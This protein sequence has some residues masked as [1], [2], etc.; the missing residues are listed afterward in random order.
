MKKFIKEYKKLRAIYKPLAA[1]WKI[2]QKTYE[3][4][5]NGVLNRFAEN[6]NYSK[7]FKDAF[8]SDRKYK[9]LISDFEKLS[10]KFERYQKSFSD[11]VKGKVFFVKASLPETMTDKA[12]YLKTAISPYGYADFPY[13]EDFF[14]EMV[15]AFKAN[16]GYLEDGTHVL[17]LTYYTNI[18]NLKNIQFI[19]KAEYDAVVK[20]SENKDFSHLVKEKL[21]S[22]LDK[23]PIIDPLLDIACI[24]ELIKNTDVI[25][26]SNI[27]IENISK[28]EIVSNISDFLNKFILH[29]KKYCEK[30]ETSA[31]LDWSPDSRKDKD[32]SHIRNV[33]AFYD[34]KKDSLTVFPL[35]YMFT[36]QNFI[37]TIPWHFEER[38][39]R[40]V[41]NDPYH[42]QLAKWAIFNKKNL[43]KDELDNFNRLVSFRF[44]QFGDKFKYV[45]LIIEG[46]F[47]EVYEDMLVDA[48]GQGD[49]QLYRFER[50]ADNNWIDAAGFIDGEFLGT[51]NF[52]A[53]TRVDLREDHVDFV[54]TKVKDPNPNLNKLKVFEWEIKSI[55]FL[56]FDE[57]CDLNGTSEEDEYGIYDLLKEHELILPEKNLTVRKYI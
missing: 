26:Y 56:K 36:S 11:F 18:D 8:I 9:K 29:A 30:L 42:K 10:K 51:Y 45:Y 14:S 52:L 3:L 35:I 24:P 48:D 17:N 20:K 12:I 6:S 55:S 19:S 28:F 13:K 4:N 43:K 49:Y 54:I 41:Y 32:W 16:T 27:E 2:V 22:I 50:R 33:V 15:F 1:K 40:W 25:E 7:I 31:L 53:R 57:V 44:N 5:P 46:K 47:E 39:N 21:E 38:V 37:L 23:D 34:K